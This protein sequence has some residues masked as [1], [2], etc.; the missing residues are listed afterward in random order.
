MSENPP[1][2]ETAPETPEAEFD[3]FVW[4]NLRRNYAANYVHGMLGMTG[5]RLLNAPT[6]VPAYL[7]MLSGSNAVVGLGMALQQLGGV[8]SPVVGAAH[9]EHRAKLMPAAVL[10]GTLMRLPILAMAVTGWLMH[11]QPLLIT[12]IVM[13]FL[14]G[15]FSGS[16]RVVFQLL[17]AKVI[18]ISRRGR[19]QAWRNFTG[20]AIA[21]GLAYLAGR[22]L[23]ELNVLGNGY[24]T[25]F[26]LAFLLT[27][28]GL[29]VL[30][31]LI[32]E[33]V[34]PHLPQQTRFRDRMKDFPAL[35]AGDRDYRNFLIAQLFAMAARVAAPF[36]VLHAGKVAVLTGAQL[37]LL[38]LA[39]L[40]ADTL[41]NLVWGY[42][43]D[44]GGFR[45][46]FVASLV[47]FIGSTVLLMVSHNTLFL[48]LAFFGLGA[49]QSGYS[50]S[51]STMV[52]EFG[53]RQDVAMR[54]GISSTVE[55]LMSFVGPLAGGVIAD[56]L[57]YGP[58]FGLSIGLQLVALTVLVVA[59]KEPRLRQIP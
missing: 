25:T 40:G 2:P 18:P 3:R 53:A 46:S 9:V 21:A 50:M 20:G 15:L 28:A 5:F 26:M 8:V 37:G 48:A 22:Y 36:Y 19:L 17:M 49:A 51:S 24:A 56:W 43:G 58:V 6:I 41:S 7:H 32:R 13:L 29:T 33:P 55:G 57:G 45:S 54:L 47:L 12:L 14:M 23:I 44:R 38:S 31:V 27:S 34:S 52:L 42:L 16:Q 1:S 35:V 11:G 39:Y 59:V 10:L 4:A 30:Q